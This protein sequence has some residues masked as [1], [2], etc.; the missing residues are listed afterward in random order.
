MTFGYLVFGHRTGEAV[1]RSS[2]LHC[3]LSSPVSKLISNL[4]SISEATKCAIDRA[5]RANPGHYNSFRDYDAPIGR[6]L[7]SD[8]IGLKGGGNTYAYVAA[9]PLQQADRRGLDNPGLGPYEAQIGVYDFGCFTRCWTWAQFMCAFSYGA[10]REPGAAGLRE[11]RMAEIFRVAAIDIAL[12]LG[13]VQIARANG[14]SRS[15]RMTLGFGLAL[16]LVEDA[17]RWFVTVAIGF[18]SLEFQAPLDWIRYNVSL[19][20]AAG[21][22]VV[23]FATFG[24]VVGQRKSAPNSAA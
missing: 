14:L 11:S 8:P 5:Q 9:K 10:S 22:V 15:I 20:G 16:L 12:V 6:Y 2:L 19:V 17:I 3:L 7:E 21:A 18:V 13:V 23:S 1:G 4:T 24:I